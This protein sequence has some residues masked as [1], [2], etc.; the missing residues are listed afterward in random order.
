M[1][2]KKGEKVVEVSDDDDDDNDDHPRH[3]KKDSSDKDAQAEDKSKDVG[4]VKKPPTNTQRRR[5]QVGSKPS[6]KR[7]ETERVEGVSASEAEAEPQAEI[8]TQAEVSMPS[9]PSITK[10]PQAEAE[11][12][13]ELHIVDPVIRTPSPSTDEDADPSTISKILSKDDVDSDCD[14]EIILDKDLGTETDSDVP[15]SNLPSLEI[16]LNNARAAGATRTDLEELEIIYGQAMSLGISLAEMVELKKEEKKVRLAEERD[17]ESYKLAK[18]MALEELSQAPEQVEKTGLTPFEAQ[19]LML[20]KANI[21]A[22][23][24]KLEAEKREQ[25]RAIEA[26]RAFEAGERHKVFRAK[27]LQKNVNFRLSVEPITKVLIKKQ[28]DHATPS[29]TIFRSG[30]LVGDMAIDLEN[31]MALGYTEWIEIHRL[32]QG[33]TSRHRDEV[34]KVLN[35]LCEDIAKLNVD[36]STAVKPKP[37]TDEQ[38]NLMARQ[39]KKPRLL[40]TFKP[41]PGEHTLIDQMLTQ[42]GDM[43]KLNLSM[44]PNAP[45]IDGLFLEVP[46][47]GLVYRD[48]QRNWCFQRA[49][50]LKLASPVHLFILRD[51]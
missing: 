20:Q 26:Q 23:A 19:K 21:A 36:T 51:I 29:I 33:S 30:K 10:A 44:P 38:R 9:M 25:Q 6:R 45:E 8:P 2:T 14:E 32:A 27:K 12:E 11:T 5:K 1:M 46:E 7:V 41:S 4:P 34:L 16:V 37:L 49:S 42:G 48:L 50:E 22:Q 31:I 24:E 47:Q 3:D 39:R 15:K 18:S 17:A 13:A 28:K 35:H 40:P 43:S